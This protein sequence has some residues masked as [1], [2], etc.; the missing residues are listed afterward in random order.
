[1][2]RRA[3]ND[4]V[5]STEDPAME[6]AP[7]QEDD[8]EGRF[9]YRTPS[10]KNSHASTGEAAE[11]ETSLDHPGV[12]VGGSGQAECVGQALRWALDAMHNPSMAAADWLARDIDPGSS[13]AVAM[14]S[15]PTTTLE[16]VRQAKMAFKTMRIVGEKSADRRVGARMYAA[17]IAAGIVHHGKRI[18]TQSDAALRRG[19]TALL[20]DQKMPRELRDLAGKALCVFHDGR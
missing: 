3:D 9:V 15:S 19:F 10:R 5:R 11:A 2:T 4:N 18:S 8:E 7:G 13:S 16:Q 1:M 17:A 14:L 6:I 12:T 20:N